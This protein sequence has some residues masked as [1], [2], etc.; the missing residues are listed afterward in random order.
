MRAR[1]ELPLLLLLAATAAE[2]YKNYI[3]GGGKDKRVATWLEQI[4]K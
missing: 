1:R 4:D 3:D 2:C